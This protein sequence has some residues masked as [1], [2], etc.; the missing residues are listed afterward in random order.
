MKI[1]KL[2]VIVLLLYVGIEVN[3]QVFIGIKTSAIFSEY[4]DESGLGVVSRFPEKMEWF[5]NYETGFSISGLLQ[6][7]FNKFIAI[8]FEPGFSKRNNTRS[9]DNNLIYDLPFLEDFDRI[10]IESPMK[11][12]LRL[13]LFKNKFGIYSSIGVNPHKYVST[14]NKDISFDR[15]FV[16]NSKLQ[17]GWEIKKI[18][19]VGIDLKLGPHTILVDCDFST[20]RNKLNPESDFNL[21]DTHIGIGYLKTI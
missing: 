17:E 6:V 12:K 13:P 16:P 11:L 3:A 7:N 1:K 10:Y 9:P 21:K 19:G 14:V 2:F 4:T 8:G 20:K 18:L 5:S 15:S